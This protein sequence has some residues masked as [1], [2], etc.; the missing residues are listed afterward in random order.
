MR[1]Q[2]S[3]KLLAIFVLLIIA[4]IS[5]AGCSESALVAPE[6]TTEWANTANAFRGDIIDGEIDGLNLDSEWLK[7]DTQ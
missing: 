3:L 2:Q 1:T 6:G 7:G 4:A 5:L